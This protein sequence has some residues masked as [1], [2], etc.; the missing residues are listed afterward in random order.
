MQGNKDNAV[1]SVASSEQQSLR[2]LTKEAEEEKD[3]NKELNDTDDEKSEKV[4]Q[5][6]QDAAKLEIKSEPEAVKQEPQ[7]ADPA[8]KKNKLETDI[9]RWKSCLLRFS[10]LN[11]AIPINDED[12]L[13]NREHYTITRDEF[14]SGHHSKFY[15]C[16]KDGIEQMCK[17]TPLKNINLKYKDNI[18]KNAIK[19]MRYLNE[20]QYP[21]I[22]QHYAFFQ[23]PSKMYIFEEPL[24]SMNLQSFVK[25]NRKPNSAT[26]LQKIKKYARDIAEA[27]NHLYV[28]GISHN[29]IKLTN[30]GF[31]ID[32]ANAKLVG[33]NNAKP[34]F[35]PIKNEEILSPKHS[36]WSFNH[37]PETSKGSFKCLPADIWSF[38]ILIVC[39]YCLKPPFSVKTT[40]FET[41]LKAHLHRQ[42]VQPEETLMQ[43][44]LKC[45]EKDPNNRIDIGSILLHPYFN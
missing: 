37:A 18:L 16:K 13:I 44:L 3:L 19:I 40:K 6:Q 17:I 9:A 34:L 23:S 21:S 42:F 32:Q 22:V 4:R 7:V 35:D 8:L 39:L 45:F 31:T 28:I 38:G 12:F 30:V 20:N 29:N 5:E 25:K 41:R 43:L 1:S 2:E 36:E 33:F 15:K 10:Q 26:Y 27:I 11:G 14:A 24:S